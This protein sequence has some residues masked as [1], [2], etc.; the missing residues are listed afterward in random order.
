MR[1]ALTAIFLL[2]AAPQAGA[3]HWSEKTICGILDRGEGVDEVARLAR[4][5]PSK[6]L[7]TLKTD[8][9]RKNVSKT[10]RTPDRVVRSTCNYSYKTCQQDGRDWFVGVVRCRELTRFNTGETFDEPA[11]SHYFYDL[12]TR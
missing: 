7:D 10:R 2:A 12:S 1:A 11:E 4:L 5:R 8:F 3:V 9:S 6:S